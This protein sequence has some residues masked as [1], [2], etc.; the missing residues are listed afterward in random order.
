MIHFRVLTEIDDLEEIARIA[1]EVWGVNQGIPVNFMRAIAVH[2]GVIIGA[3]ER[4]DP[5]GICAALTALHPRTL[6][7]LL[8]GIRPD[9]QGQ[10]IGTGLKW[11]QRAWALQHGFEE[12][13]WT[14]DPLQRG[15]AHFNLRL[16]GA[17]AVSYLPNFYGIMNDKITGNLPSDRL[18]A[19]WHLRDPTVERI[20]HG[21]E[22]RP[23]P[24]PPSSDSIILDIDERHMPIVRRLGDQQ[25]CYARV[26][27][28]L[29]DLQRQ[30]AE[31]A[32]AWRLAQRETL[33]PLFERG[34]RAVDFLSDGQF[35][36]YFL[37]KTA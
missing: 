37:V 22:I 34:F 14:F 20:A 29:S 5:V 26:P 1:E 23:P 17:T 15:N 35:H 16:L 33:I 6:W 21:C 28:S 19:Q 7:S 4:G 9:K 25:Y 18:L 27:P 30:N 10:G 24:P 11:A 2:A 13:H 36:G 12:I 8:T 31:A 3:Y 32:L